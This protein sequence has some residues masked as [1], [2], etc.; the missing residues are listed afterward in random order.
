M[1]LHLTIAY[2][3]FKWKYSGVNFEVKPGGPRCPSP[4]PLPRPTF[5]HCVEFAN[6][7]KIPS[8]GKHLN[9]VSHTCRLI[10][11]VGK[12]ASEYFCRGKLWGFCSP[13]AVLITWLSVTRW[14]AL[15]ERREAHRVKWLPQKWRHLPSISIMWHHFYYHQRCSKAYPCPKNSL[16]SIHPSHGLIAFGATSI[17]DGSIFWCGLWSTELLQRVGG[18]IDR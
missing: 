11:T 7:K 3:N 8:Q 10:P 18:R 6:L 15:T 17:S 2:K 4:R 12:D 13:R 5:L 1:L 9:L 14:V 16:P